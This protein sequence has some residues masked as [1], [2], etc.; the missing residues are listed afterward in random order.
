M[1]TDL[2][3]VVV[4]C[5]KDYDCI[6]KLLEKINSRVL[7]S[8]E[9]ILID[10]REN[11][12][13]VKIYLPDNARMYSEEYNTYQF[14][15]RRFAVQFVKG[16]YVW[17]VDADDEVL[18]VRTDL[19]KYLNA[20]YDFIVFGNCDITE[21]HQLV[22]GTVDSGNAEGYLCTRKIY[23]SIWQI[24]WNKWIETNFLKK[25]AS[26]L[27]EGKL[28]VASEDITVIRLMLKYGKKY[29]QIRD[30]LYIYH[31][32]RAGGNSKNM[33]V[34]KFKH[35]MLGLDEA[36]KITRKYLTPEECE[37]TDCE[38]YVDTSYF[39]NNVVNYAEDKDA[40]Y[41]VMLNYFTEQDIAICLLQIQKFRLFSD[42]DINKMVDFYLSKVN[43]S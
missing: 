41:K 23:R 28:I 42:V 21:N 39:L 19:V 4:F 36:N 8:H 11:Y 17:Y 32:Y 26:L 31:K 15:A 20:D 25:I 10:N 27:P 34:E 12:K 13:S 24:L 6:P 38:N 9:I 3:I 40:C 43:F 18:K 29:I 14:E 33:S 7:I 37:A 5:D 1:E 35:I 22:N 16:R 2:S 30:I